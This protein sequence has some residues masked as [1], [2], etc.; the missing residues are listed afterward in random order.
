MKLAN[1]KKAAGNAARSIGKAA[2]DFVE[3]VK[4]GEDDTN[5][6]LVA[7]YVLEKVKGGNLH[8][9]ENIQL[10]TEEDWQEVVNQKTG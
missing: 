10:M 1:F 2:S 5:Y 4:P 7:K 9:I 8:E 6:V 3:E